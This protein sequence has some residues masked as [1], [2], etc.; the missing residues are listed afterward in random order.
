MLGGTYLSFLIGPTVP[1]P[2]PAKLVQNLE[3]V[4]V[5]QADEGRSGFQI[6]FRAGRSGPMDFLDDPVASHPLLMPF[7][8]VILTALVG[9]M[10]H[11]LMDGIITN[12]QFAPSEVPGETT[13]TVTGEDVSVMMDLKEE[14]REHPAQPKPLI[15]TLLTT[16]Y[17]QYGLVPMVIPPPTM[18]MPIPT[19]YTPVQHSTDLAFI[20]QMAQYYGY[21]FYIDPGPSPGMNIAYWG[22]PKRTGVPQRA[23]SVAMGSATNVTSFDVQYNALSA[24][25]VSGRVQDRTLGIELPVFTLTPLRFPLA[26]L[27]AHLADMP[28]VR[29]Q[30]L[31]EVQGGSVLQA[32]ARAQGITDDSADGVVS[33]SG[34]LDTA[35]YGGVL[36]P[37]SIVGIRGAGF[38]HDGFYYVKSVTHNISPDSYTQSFQL[39]REGVGSLTPVVVP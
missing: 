34:Q 4:R 19:D 20:S 37:R 15:V 1:L 7:N 28:N 39:T 2:A 3:S 23:L 9:P 31:G 36:K 22:P 17:A 6:A 8:R 16:R 30:Q 18:E 13:F 21:V 5:T 32:Y 27:P 25:T 14:I 29:Q 33:A 35:R 12:H 24:T 38:R 26:L 10:M 11:V